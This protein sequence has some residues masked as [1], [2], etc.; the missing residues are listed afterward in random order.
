MGGRQDEIKVK[1]CWGGMGISCHMLY[2]CNDM[3]V[4]SWVSVCRRLVIIIII[5][6]VYAHT[7]AISHRVQALKECI[8]LYTSALSKQ[9]TT[10]SFSQRGRCPQQVPLCGRPSCCHCESSGRRPTA[11]LSKCFFILWFRKRF[12]AFL[13]V[14]LQTQW[15]RNGTYLQW[16]SVETIYGGQNKWLTTL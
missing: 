16:N 15:R 9:F 14:L 2:C 13:T 3:C 6:G 4:L 11:S 1:N 8:V 10:D 12:T 7:R 5:Q